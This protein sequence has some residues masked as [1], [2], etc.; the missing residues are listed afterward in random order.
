MLIGRPLRPEEEDWLDL[1][2][3]V[4]VADLVCHRGENEAW[5]RT[6]TLGLP[7]RAPTLISQWLPLLQ[8]I[9]GRMTHDHLDIHIR[10]DPAPGPSRFPKRRP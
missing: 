9:F 1:L 8:E 3:A 2:R 10:Q 6:I 4:H 7:L 5:N